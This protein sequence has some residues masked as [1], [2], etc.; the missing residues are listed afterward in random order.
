MRSRRD[1]EGGGVATVS[2]FLRRL[3]LLSTLRRI[4]VI[5]ERR[6][7]QVAQLFDDPLDQ[8]VIRHFLIVS[9]DNDA[10]SRL[11]GFGARLE[12]KA[13]PTEMNLIKY[14]HL[15]TLSEA[16]RYIEDK[17]PNIIF[18]YPDFASS[19][20]LLKFVEMDREL[21]EKAP[22]LHPFIVWVVFCD[23]IWWRHTKEIVD[24]HPFGARFRKYYELKKNG[25]DR[26]LFRDFTRVL[27][28]CHFDFVLQMLADAVR[29]IKDKTAAGMTEEQIEKFI[30][31]G[32][33][34]LQSL[35]GT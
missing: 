18:L 23:P 2:F 35:L 34:P 8:Y 32:M 26:E 21:F 17:K 30:E 9:K 3:L 15:T 28:R 24:N 7:W 33:R 12:A 20:E 13:E 14:A 4:V 29:R 6:G 5:T 22:A 25:P 10:A 1:E 19:K 16:K 31:K 27:T 11:A